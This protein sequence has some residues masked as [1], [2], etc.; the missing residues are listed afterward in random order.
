MKK[1]NKFQINSEKLMNNEEL[2]ALKGGYGGACCWCYTS[3]GYG[4]YHMI[5]GS[6]TQCTALIAYILDMQVVV[7]TANKT[8]CLEAGTILKPASYYS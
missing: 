1:L 7:G 2:I 4:G 5:S 6:P 8:K 3:Q